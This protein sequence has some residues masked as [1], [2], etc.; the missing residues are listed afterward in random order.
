MPSTDHRRD[1]S[2]QINIR[3]TPDE[4]AELRAQAHRRGMSIVRL[5]LDAVRYV[6]RLPYNA[7]FGRPDAADADAHHPN[8]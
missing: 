6:A 2:E 1:R 7:G 3:L 4:A 5:I 8:T